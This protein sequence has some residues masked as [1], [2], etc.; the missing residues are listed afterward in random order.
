MVDHHFPDMLYIVIWSK[1]HLG[2]EYLVFRQAH[3]DG[4]NMLLKAWELATVVLDGFGK[5][6]DGIINGAKKK[7]G[8]VT[9]T[10]AARLWFMANLGLQIF[11]QPLH[12]GWWWLIS[13]CPVPF[14]LRQGPCP[15]LSKGAGGAAPKCPKHHRNTR[16]MQNCWHHWV[17]Y[18]RLIYCTLKCWTILG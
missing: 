16:D 5:K 12:K 11:N 6:H 15:A 2:I 4:S 17:N 10:L 9:M 18:G 7:R 8:S 13:L 1:G 14:R 3:V